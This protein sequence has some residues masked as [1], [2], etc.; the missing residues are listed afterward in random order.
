MRIGVVTIHYNYKNLGCT[1][2]AYSLV[3]HLKR[4]CAAVEVVDQRYPGKLLAVGEPHTPSALTQL[5][6]I[7]NELPRSRTFLTDDHTTA[8]SYMAKSYDLLVYG[9]DE[10]WKWQFD[11]DGKQKY[12]SLITPIPNIFWPVDLKVSKVS[13]AASIGR[14]DTTIPPAIKE[15]LCRSL[16]GF[17]AIS[18]RDLRSADMVR[19]ISGREA[20]IVP[21]PVFLE[22]LSAECDPDLILHK[23]YVAG[24]RPGKPIAGYYMHGSKPGSIDGA[25]LV[26]L[27]ECQLTPVE[28]WYVPKLIDLMITNTHHG[29]L[30]ALIHNTPCYVAKPYPSKVRDHVV[31]YSLPEVFAGLGD[32]LD[33]W[34]YGLVEQLVQ[35]DR[36]KGIQWLNSVMGKHGNNKEDNN[37]SKILISPQ[38]RPEIESFQ[39]YL[40]EIADLPEF[41]NSEAQTKLAQV[42]TMSERPI[43]IGGCGRSGTSMLLAILSCHPEIAAID[44]E[45]HV[46]C[47]TGYTRHPVLSSP[48]RPNILADILINRDIPASCTR[49]CEKTPKNI[50]FVARILDYLDSAARFI[51]MVRDGRDVVTSRRAT[52]PDKLHITPARWIEDVEAGKLYDDHPQV[53][54]LKYE[55]LVTNYRESLMNLCRFLELEYSA[56]FMDYPV[57]VHMIPYR[58]MK[59][60][61]LRP[62]DAHSIGRWQD[63]AFASPVAALMA[64]P[65]AQSLL[66]HYGYI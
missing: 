43:I 15:Y 52:E 23:L 41:T 25:Q 21:D 5:K 46:F 1:L 40:Q 50:L 36:N 57:S 26:N 33:K 29:V 66:K 37:T 11:H 22:D 54:V 17:D 16:L 20:D 12:K 32:I 27:K 10:I 8:E 53:Y 65:H 59:S 48:F 18:V 63:P 2:Q 6:F 51:H 55:S 61:Q 47:P 14:S 45:T 39:S 31:R 13:Y 58:G 30:V 24:V 64:N 62:V 49:W 38:A 60:L 44:G 3:S 35:E 28:F 42:R 56:K 19:N 7:E 4:Y 34:N 9:S